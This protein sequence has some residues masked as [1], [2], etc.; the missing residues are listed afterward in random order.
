MADSSS[1]L[2]DW[3]AWL[4]G[5]KSLV[6]LAGGRVSMRALHTLSHALRMRGEVQ[7]LI[8]EDCVL[9]NA[10][11]ALLGSVNAWPVS[12]QKVELHRCILASPDRLAPNNR[13]M[14]VNAII[15]SS[16]S[17]SHRAAA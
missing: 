6:Q 17:S 11:C 16:S 7:Y 2:Q 8:L 1:S 5:R 10:C 4:E 14:V 12:L 3:L 13:V 9:D 15:S